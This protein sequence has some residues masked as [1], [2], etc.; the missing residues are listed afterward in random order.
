MYVPSLISLF[1]KPVISHI[2]EK[3]ILLYIV[4]ALFSEVVALLQPIFVSFVAISAVLCCCFKVMSVVRI[5]PF[6]CTDKAIVYFYWQIA[7][8]GQ[9]FEST[10]KAMQS[11]ARPRNCQFSKTSTAILT[12]LI[13]K[14]LYGDYFSRVKQ[15]GTSD[16]MD[17]YVGTCPCE[18]V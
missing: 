11:H 3:A 17:S 5:L 16:M 18:T 8:E 14:A 15:G 9:S 10:V 1:S 6:T 12:K 4:F 13:F 7:D 2:E